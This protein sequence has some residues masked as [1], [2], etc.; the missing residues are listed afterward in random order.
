MIPTQTYRPWWAKTAGLTALTLALVTACGGDGG[1]TSAGGQ[2][3]R[4]PITYVQF[5]DQSG[6]LGP[7]VER[8]NAAHPGEEVTLK[9]TAAG[10]EHED[11]TQNFQAKSG[12]YDVVLVDVVWTAEFAARGWLVPLEGDMAIDTSGLLPPTLDAATYNGKVYAGP[13]L[14]DAGLLYYRSDLVAEPPKTLD[15]MWSMCPIAE[16]HGIDC[17]AGQFAQYEGLT[18]NAT[19]WMNAYGA[20]L[21]DETGKPTVNSPQA[22]EGL[23]RL[24]EHVENGDIPK[25]ALTYREE[26]SRLAFQNGKTLFLRNW[27]Y[28]YSLASTD[29][30]SAVKGKFAVAPLPG[31]D[32]P[33][34]STLGGHMAG[35]SAY[36]E[37]KATARDFVQFLMSEKEQRIALET[38]SYAPVLTS[39]YGEPDLVRKFPY[40]PQLK[41]SIENAEARP[42][43]PFYPAVTEAIQTNAFLAL[44]GQKTPARAVA[45]MQAAMVA[46][47][48]R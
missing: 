35:V 45:D 28:A 5:K 42:E 19:E 1:G 13:K 36:S 21:V 33:G 12:A 24:V 47:S 34:T 18:V 31:V 22:V 3:D 32:G 14:S 41:T 44:Q 6:L 8:W 16:K 7:M 43:T 23:S 9:E 17:F 2:D 37:H 26:E 10:Q 30:S 38:G 48:R 46:G 40:L 20:Q 29:A 15:E 27:P 39:L 11:L 4:G 25:K